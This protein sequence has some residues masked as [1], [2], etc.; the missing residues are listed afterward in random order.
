MSSKL[1]WNLPSR[2][3]RRPRCKAALA[4]VRSS[5]SESKRTSSGTA[6]GSDPAHCVAADDGH[7]AAHIIP[8]ALLPKTQCLNQVA[9]LIGHGLQGDDRADGPRLAKLTQGADTCLGAEMPAGG[10]RRLG[11][12]HR[13]EGPQDLEHRLGGP[14]IADSPGAKAATAATWESGSSKAWMRR[15]TAAGPSFI[16]SRPIWMR[17]RAGPAASVKNRSLPPSDLAARSSASRDWARTT[18]AASAAASCAIGTADGGSAAQEAERPASYC[19]SSPTVPT[20]R[21]VRMT[22]SVHLQLCPAPFD[23]QRE[24]RELQAQSPTARGQ[25]HPMRPTPSPAEGRISSP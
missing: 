17:P 12:R 22:I 19:A 13:E 2:T 11:L 3:P 24:G 9:G 4:R 6:A 8:G 18:S 25:A 7:D 20:M 23:C 1:P 16:I 10:L 15:G 14:P 5:A 21:I